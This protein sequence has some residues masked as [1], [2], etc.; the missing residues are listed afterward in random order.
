MLGI[1]IGVLSVTTVVSLGNGFKQQIQGE[2]TG[3]GA[4]LVTVVPGNIFERDDDGNIA[5]NDSGFTSAVGVSTLT[6][7]DLDTIKEIEGVSAATP[8]VPVSGLIE[9][10]DEPVEGATLIATDNDL[11]EVLNQSIV[12]GSMF[13]GDKDENIA[14]I[15]SELA[16]DLFGSTDAV[17][18]IINVRGERFVITGVIDANEEQALSELTGFNFGRTVYIPLEKGKTYNQGSTTLQEIDLTVVD[19]ADV[20]SVVAKIEELVTENHGG[21]MD[22]SVVKQDDILS[23]TDTFTSIATQFVAA[24]AGISLLVGG[25]GIMNIM[26][27]SVTE[28]TREIGLRKAIGASRAHI[29][30]QFLIESVILSALGGLLGVGL[31]YAAV[32]GIT[33]YTDFTGAFDL[34]TILL[35]TGVSAGVG[36]VAGLWPAWQAAKKDPIH[37]LRHE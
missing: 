37:S 14:V 24:I 5:I 16:V 30:L 28:R 6:T 21:Q 4:N 15:G 29:L 1:I 22:F 32:A 35:A 8:I 13:S 31:A 17:T 2:I 34:Y 18:G 27:V 9:Y 26:L 20:D 11:P 12:R 10:K 25:I 7:E 36:V 3:L 23:L 19:E 33:I